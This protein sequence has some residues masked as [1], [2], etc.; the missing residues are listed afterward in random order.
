LMSLAESLPAV[1]SPSW[2][3]NSPRTASHPSGAVSSV[4]RSCRYFSISARYE[5]GA[6]APIA[7]AVARISGGMGPNLHG[8]IGRACSADERSMVVGRIF[9]LSCGALLAGSTAFAQHWG[10]AGTPRDGA[11]FYRDADYGGEYFC[12]EAGGV[13]TDLPRDMNDRISSLRIFGHA[14]VV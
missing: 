14:L 1:L 6:A 8:N 9:V 4:T 11:C 12:V 2:S 5:A 13:L 10:H 7:S 3:Q